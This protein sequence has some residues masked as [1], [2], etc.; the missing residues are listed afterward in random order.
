MNLRLIKYVLQLSQIC[1]VGQGLHCKTKAIKNN[2]RVPQ[3][4]GIKPPKYKLVI[5]LN[6]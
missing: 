6:I 5:L 4:G 1:Y 3:Y 2:I